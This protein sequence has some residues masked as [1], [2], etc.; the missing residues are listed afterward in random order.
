MRRTLQ[1]TSTAT[2]HPPPQVKGLMTTEH[3]PA[4]PGGRRPTMG[5]VAERVGVS[6][7]LVGIVF[8]NDKGVSAETRGRILAAAAELGYQPDVAAQTLRQRSSKYLGVVFSP[9][10]SAE[11]DIIES[12]YVAAAAGGYGVVLS[13]L[14]SSRAATTA[15][16]EVLG[17]RCAALLMIGSVVPITDLR[18]AAGKLPVVL[19]GGAK[20][21][22]T[23]CDYV[24]SAGDV[25]IAQI[26]DYLA[27]LGHREIAYIYGSGMASADLRH[28]GYLTAMTKLGLTPRTVHIA[29]DYTENSGAAAASILLRDS[30]F[31]T[32]VIAANDQSASGFIH[33]C[34]RVGL[35][36]P[37]DVSVTGFDDSRIAQ[38][39]YLQLTSMRQDGQLMAQASV[40]AALSRIKGRREPIETVIT[41]TLVIRASTD[42]PRATDIAYP[43]SPN[44]ELTGR[45]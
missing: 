24:R 22:P 18:A 35:R 7:Q 31:P 40:E 21:Q 33:A 10:N 16:E 5:D 17:Y 14:T 37:Q 42:V 41:P 11:S 20:A 9:A 19:I 32:A 39:P 2:V 44:V 4:L 34:L 3:S 45:E 23:G 8:R 43:G 28:A 30:T 1:P 29:G 38:L 15:I 36:V 12:L 25:A 6:R 27:G 13:A 26:V